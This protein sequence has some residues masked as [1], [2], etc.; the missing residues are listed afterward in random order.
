MLFSRIFINIFLIQGFMILRYRGVI[1]FHLLYSA[2]FRLTT[3]PLLPSLAAF[4]Y[5]GIFS[6]I[7]AAFFADFA[8]SPFSFSFRFRQ[9]FSSRYFAMMMIRFSS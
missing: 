6:L 2:R 4:D 7:A 8:F 9:L 1:R 5:A 3:L